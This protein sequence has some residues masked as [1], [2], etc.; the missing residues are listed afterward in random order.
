[1]NT[2][3]ARGRMLKLLALARRGEGGERDNAQRFLD[4]LL[5]QHGMSLE[6][7]ENEQQPT[8]WQRFTYKTAFGHRLL[9]QVIS[10]VLGQNSFNSRVKRGRK[11]FEVQV[12]KA[13][14]VEIDLYY[15]A[16]Q[17]DLDKAMEHTFAAFINRNKVGADT[18]QEEDRPS[19]YSDEERWQIMQMMDAMPKTSI[20]RQ[21]GHSAP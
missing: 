11:G 14:H 19:K 2:D 12:T 20:Q 3:K 7:L 15:R 10:M 8:E 17:R 21:I 16:F 13:Q 9:I 4:R 1:M 6:D 5:K 18:P